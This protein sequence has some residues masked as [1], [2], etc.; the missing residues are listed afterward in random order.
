MKNAAENLKEDS[1]QFYSMT[2]RKHRK[3]HCC[4]CNRVIISLMQKPVEKNT[5]RKTKHHKK[6]YKLLNSTIYENVKHVSPRLKFISGLQG[7]FNSVKPI[8]AIYH[9]NRLTK[10]KKTH[11]T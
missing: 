3:E 6:I 9:I 7:W 10:K 4:F 11:V 1:H 2:S 8:N 5:T